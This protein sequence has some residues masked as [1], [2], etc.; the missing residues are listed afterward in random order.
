M[1]KTG[2]SL[3][4]FSAVES[5]AQVVVLVEAAE[6]CHQVV[7]EP[8][9]VRRGEVLVGGGG[10]L[11]LLLAADL[12]LDR[13]QRGVLAHREAGAGLAV[14][15]DGQADVAR[16]DGGQRGEPAAGVAGGVD[17]EQLL[18]QL[19]ADRDGRV[20]GGVGASGDADLDLAERDLVRDLDRGLQTGAARLLDVGRGR[21]GREPRA[22]HGLAGE[23][24][25]AGVLQH[26]AGDH[27]AEPLAR[28]PEPVD[29][30]V[31]GRG[32]HVLV[33]RGRVGGVGP[34]ERDAVAAQD[35]DAT[36]GPTVE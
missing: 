9:V 13:G 12:P 4:S 19:L 35:C 10:E 16:A 28:Q 7:L 14:L 27:L 32:E 33:G 18:A 6:R 36:G 5:G 17:L 23:V 26:R 34:G 24:E 1:P 2:F 25:V 21:L 8:G 3:P 11:V 20:G 15:R 22:E 31:E 30:P 29:Q